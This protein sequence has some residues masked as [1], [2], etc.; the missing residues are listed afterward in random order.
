MADW[1]TANRESAG[2][3]PNPVIVKDAVIQ[4]YVARAFSWRDAR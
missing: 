1:R 4:V 3:A 2:I